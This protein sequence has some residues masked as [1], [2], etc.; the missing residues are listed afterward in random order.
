MQSTSGETRAPADASPLIYIVDD[1]EAVRLA[2]GM[3]V[4]SCGWRARL[5]GSAREFLET[6]VRDDANACLLLDLDLPDMNGADLL[7]ALADRKRRLPVI[8]VTAFADGV[9][10]ARA[11]RM[12]VRAV[13]RKPFH[14]YLLLDHIRAALGL[15]RA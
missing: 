7:D 4:G 1:D 12:D 15:T 6:P 10:A 14:D 8:V 3:L 11:R 2:L 13:I 5:C 9:L